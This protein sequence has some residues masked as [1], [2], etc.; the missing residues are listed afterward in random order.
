MKEYYKILDLSA[1]ASEEEIRKAYRR[2][3][4]IYHPD[5]NP[6]D[7]TAEERF[8]EIA[9]AYGV[10]MDPAKRAAF[11]RLRDT[12]SSRQQGVSGFGFSQEEILRDLFR[13]PRFNQTFHDLFQEFQQAG[14]RFDQRFFNQAFFGGHGVFGAFVWGPGDRRPIRVRVRPQPQP[15][16][17]RQPDDAGGRQPPGFLRQ[18]G[19]KISSFLRGV[20]K[21]LPAGSSLDLDLNFNLTVNPTVAREGTWVQIA[22]ARDTG[23]ETLRVRIPPHTRS[24][25]R[26]RLR[27][28][29]QQQNAAV[30]DLYLT[31][32]LA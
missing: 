10:L 11:D 18:L 31:I 9:E 26:L 27:G 7:A 4:L 32:H 21:A 22:L 16:I 20:P 13:D 5:R 24:G 29:G 25:T 8:K 30:G 23:Q 28:K 15:E 1:N 3:A 6:G 17:D 12:S 2:L 14:F 19:R